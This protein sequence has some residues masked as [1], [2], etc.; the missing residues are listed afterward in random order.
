MDHQQLYKRI[1]LDSFFNSVLGEERIAF[2]QSVKSASWQHPNKIFQ[3][4]LDLGTV[5]G[6]Y[7]AFFTHAGMNSYAVNI[8]VDAL[9]YAQET[10]PY[11]LFVPN[12]VPADIRT[13]PFRDSS[14]DLV[15]MMT[16]TFSHLQKGTHL[17]ALDEMTRILSPGGIAVISDWNLKVKA[18][19][20]FGWYTAEQQRELR[21]NH[22]GFPYL[23]QS[24]EQRNLKILQ[25]AILAEQR[26]YVV[27]A[28]KQ[29]KTL[30]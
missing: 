6:F 7:P 4:G 11:G 9:R 15:S 19:D 29:M 3:R 26:L 2:V 21:E 27:A 14:F 18:Q 20:F 5:T 25:K 12:A 13:L 8:L 23:C 16:G 17:Q 28:R 10:S 24:L 22:Y 30:T 1:D